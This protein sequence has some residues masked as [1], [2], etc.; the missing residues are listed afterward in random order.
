MAIQPRVFQTWL[1]NTSDIVK[2]NKHRV[3]RFIVEEVAS[4]QRRI[5]RFVGE[6]DL[7]DGR[8]EEG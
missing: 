5:V 6:I 7:C 8:Y 1:H 4:E 2:D 3:K